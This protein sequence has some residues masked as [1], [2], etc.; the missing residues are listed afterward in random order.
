M[1]LNKDIQEKQQKEQK[2]KKNWKRARLAAGIL[3]IGA[4][5]HHLHDRTFD[6]EEKFEA[7]YQ[8][9]DYKG[10]AAYAEHLK[11]DG[12][13]V[14]FEEY[15]MYSVK[16]GDV[17][18]YKAMR[19]ADDGLYGWTDFSTRVREKD[20]L[21]VL[22]KAAVSGNPEMLNLVMQDK[23]VLDNAELEDVPRILVSG[24]LEG[25]HPKQAY[26]HAKEFW[27]NDLSL[28]EGLLG[29]LNSTYHAGNF[30]LSFFT[31]DIKNLDITDVQRALLSDALRKSNAYDVSAYVANKISDPAVR[32]DH[33]TDILFSASVYNRYDTVKN[34]SDAYPFATDAKKLQNE[35]AIRIFRR[36]YHTG[37]QKY[38]DLVG[39][40]LTDE[41]GRRIL[42]MMRDEDQ[43]YS[44]YDVLEF[45]SE[46][47]LSPA[48]AIIVFHEAVQTENLRLASATFK[49]FA[50][51]YD[52]E[53]FVGLVDRQIN[54]TDIM[55]G[56][57]FALQ[58]A[59]TMQESGLLPLEAQKAILPIFSGASEHVLAEKWGIDPDEAVKGSVVDAA[60]FAEDGTLPEEAAAYIRML[61]DQLRASRKRAP[62]PT[63]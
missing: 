11:R 6:V 53:D 7:A 48:Y 44:T 62:T 49:G 35:T 15:F 52:V 46:H 9:K 63:R 39:V 28:Y 33:L 51:G 38:A 54:R 43:R 10:I 16:S 19:S 59:Q 24:A 32:D 56:E 60:L 3:T 25:D 13:N 2:R 29:V 27:A 50:E 26:E 42:Q 22:Y 34:I 12:W 36:G 41:A 21:T 45:A 23:Y 31:E 37:A 47:D 14:D 20:P 30:D 57:A 61:E 4:G 5:A 1:A 18:A 17:T 8:T 40:D 55:N 58:L